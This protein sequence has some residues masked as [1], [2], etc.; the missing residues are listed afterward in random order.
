MKI[1]SI[2]ILLIVPPVRISKTPSRF[3]LGL[4]YIAAVLEQEGYSV[5]VLDLNILRL[6]KEE[7]E[8]AIKNA[9]KD[10][11]I[12][13]M[14]GMI[15]M[16]KTIS[17]ISYIIKSNR[18]DLPVLVGG[19]IAM[20]LQ[21]IILKNS[22]IDILI[23]GEGEKTVISLI[24]TLLDKGDLNN[25]KG[26]SYLENNKCKSTSVSVRIDDLDSLPFP[27]YHLFPFKSYLKN[28][29]F[30][31]DIIG[32]RGCPYQCT[33]C[34][35]NFGSAVRFRSVNSIIEEIRFLNFFYNVKHIYLE[36][37]LFVQKKKFIEEFCDKIKKINGVT[38]S[39]CARVNT[40]SLDLLY[41]MSEANCISLMLGI[42]SFSN[43]ILKEMKKEVSSDQI[44][45]VCSWMNEVG[46]RI[47]PGLIIGMPS[48]TNSTIQMT[49]DG[50]IQNKIALNKWSYAFATPY[51]GTELYSKARASGLIDNEY[52]Y[53]KMLCLD[54]DTCNMTINLTEFT[55]AE[56]IIKRAEAMESVNK[57]LKES[58]NIKKIIIGEIYWIL[59]VGKKIF[60][61]I[62]KRLN[63]KITLFSSVFA[64]HFKS[65]LNEK[66]SKKLFK[67]S[68]K[69]VEIEVFSFCNR[70]CWFCPNHTIDR[71]S[72]NFFMDETIFEKILNNLSEINYSG[73]ISFSRYNEPLSEQAIFKY[74]K[75]TKKSVPNAMLHLNTNGDFFNKEVLEKLYAS[76]LRSLH[77]QVYLP[78]KKYSDIQAY[79]LVSKKIKEYNLPYEFSSS[80]SMERLEYKLLYKNMNIKIYTRN[81]LLNGTDRGGLIGSLKKKKRKS[82]CLIPFK[83]IYIDYNGKVVPCCNIRSD[84]ESHFSYILGDLSI[85]NRNVFN[86]FSS[87]VSVRKQLIG[88]WDKRKPCNSCSF[89]NIPLTEKNKKDND[90]LLR[91]FDVKNVT[92]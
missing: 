65:N 89:H 53:L 68:I 82:P 62:Q 81:F 32:S 21:E 5:S 86:I 63:H 2:K 87:E 67:K 24:H 70:K 91:K 42:E 44:K 58:I 22:K 23:M 28:R 15:T 27:A 39:A 25:V 35:R 34:F 78:D 8:K 52:E 56:L 85:N 49:V 60:D 30:S 31:T 14:G 18:P 43:D 69:L 3:P 51:P 66:E 12:V 38:W 64:E 40:L 76:G 10:V 16:F 59:R 61:K 72:K 80:L 55:D 57:S 1:A 88:F 7:E 29:N 79:E 17:R 6:I 46:M 41:R 54:G 37:E 74:I 84:V 45:K 13:G 90:R 73:T 19:P 47:K 11:A 71:F 92:L 48:E 83:D 26:I 75:R 77:I 36:D 33:F 9:I 20:N 50:C 4:G